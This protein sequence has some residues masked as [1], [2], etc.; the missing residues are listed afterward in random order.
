[1]PAMT[2]RRCTPEEAAH[3]VHTRDTVAFGLGPGIPPAFFT[4][5]GERDDWEELVV[6]G[7]LLLDYFK[8]LTKPGVLRSGRAH[9]V[10]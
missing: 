7:A 6:G 10:G 4:A 5:L 8:V 1:M 3:L 2:P 9:S